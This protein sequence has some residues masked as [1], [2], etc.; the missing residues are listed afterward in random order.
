[1]D[2]I[3]LLVVEDEDLLLQAITKKLSFMNINSVTARS[4]AEAKT[5]LDTATTP[6]DAVWL[7][8][9][10][11]DSRGIDVLEHIKSKP[12]TANIPVFVVSNSASEDK[13]TKMLAL[14]ASRYLVKAEH[15]L[16][17]IIAIIKNF[18]SV[19][20]GNQTS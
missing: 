18:I 11:Q 10:L 19:E 2:T 7:D 3:T 6:P 5:I 9:T 13:V 4:A 17:D 12:E 16:E 1:M 20:K 8:Y 15:R 14:G